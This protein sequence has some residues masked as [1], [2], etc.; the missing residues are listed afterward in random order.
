MACGGGGDFG[1]RAQGSG[2]EEG[3][4]VGGE[5]GLCGVNQI[6]S[7]I[8]KNWINIMA[9]ERTLK[10]SC[11]NI[12]VHTKHHADEYISFWKL[13][14]KLKIKSIRGNVALMFGYSRKISKN[15]DSYIFGYIY[16]FLD[17]DPSEPWFDI[18]K[19][20]E[21]ADEDVAQ[22]NI[23][24]KLKPNLSE[25]PYIFDPK[26]H[27]LYF[28]SG[29]TYPGVGPKSM[30]NL[31]NAI[32]SNPNILERFGEIDFTIVTD[33]KAL[34][35]LLSWP[36]IRKIYVKLERPNPTEEEDDETF[37]ERLE[38]R[39]LKSE[40]H[41]YTKESGADSIVPDEEMKTLFRTAIDN[42]VYRQSGVDKSGDSKEASSKNFPMQE[43]YQWDP[44]S[45]I[46]HDAFVD[47]VNQIK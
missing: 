20:E 38:R 39:R 17:I 27:K 11:M 10:I 13:L 21:A 32:K 24:E 15:P 41:T 46:L 43:I 18:E 2:C 28:L 19:N 26:N 34:D 44:D 23:P 6:N 30:E 25:I 29:G 12:R 5:A 37:Y 22:L 1:R 42:G 8:N 4:G 14:M 40:E 3:C 45:M 36:V 33:K 31:F 7:I 9:K 16:R 47:A 35:E